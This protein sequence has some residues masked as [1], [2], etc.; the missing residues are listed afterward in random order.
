MSVLTRRSGRLSRCLVLLA[1][2][3]GCTDS[4]DETLGTTAQAVEGAPTISS[5]KEDY[6]P[7]ETA[8]LSGS[9]FAGDEDVVVAIQCTDGCDDVF[10]EAADPGGAFTTEYPIEEHHLGATCHVTATGQSS[11][12]VAETYFTDG[13]VRVLAAPSGISFTLKYTIYDGTA[14]EA[15]GSPKGGGTRTITAGVVN[16]T[17]QIAVAPNESIKLGAGSTSLQDTAFS[18]WKLG[19]TVVSSTSTFCV[20]GPVGLLEYTANFVSPPSTNQNPIVTCQNVSATTAPNTCTTTGSV[21]ASTSD[22]DGDTV[23]CTQTPAGP[24]ALGTTPVNVSCDDGKGGSASCTGTVTLTDDDRPTLACGAAQQVECTSP[25]GASATFSA[26]ATDNCGPV[27]ASCPG[28]GSTF[29]VGTS[30][31]S[32]SATDASGND[33]SCSTTITV[34]DT[35]SPDIACPAPTA[36]ECTGN[37]QAVVDVAAAHASD[38]CGAVQTDDPGPTAYPLGTTTFSLTATDAFGN[39]SSCTTNV[40]V[41]DTTAPSITCPAPVKAECESNHQAQVDPG[42]AQGADVCG[43]ANVSGATAGSFPLGTTTTSYTARDEIGLA[44]SCTSSVTVEDTTAPSIACPTPVTTECTGNSSATVDVAAATASDL[45]GSATASDPAPASYPL[46]TTTV[47]QTATDEAGLQASC[48][49]SVTVADTTAPSISC[50]A[51]ASAECTGNHSAFVDPGTAIAADVC[52]DVSVQG[53]GAGVYPLGTTSAAYVATDALGLQSSCASAVTV[54][55]TTA[56]S[57]SC[58]APVTA[59]CTG[60]HSASVDVAPASASDVCGDVTT[61]DPAEQ[62][63]PLGTTT[64][65]ETATDDSGQTATCTTEVTIVDTTAPSISCPAPVVAE[66]TGNRSAT[67]DVAAGVASDVCGDASVTDPAAQ[68]YPLGTTPV[69]ETATDESGLTASCSTSVTVVDTTAPTF[70]ALAPQSV[71]GNCSGAALAFTKPTATDGCDLA[72]VTCSA[73]AGNSFGANTITCTAQDPSGNTATTTIAVNVIQP[74]QVRFGSPLA[75]DNVAD[76]VE[77]DADVPNIFQVKSTIPHQ[78]TLHS[79]SGADVTTSVAVS[80]TIAV[81]LRD[82]AGAA[83]DANLLLT[84][85]GVGDAGGVMALVDGKYKYNL[86]TTGYKS[87]TASSSLFFDSVVRVSYSNAPSIVAG[88]EDVRLE[89][90]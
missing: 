63:Y 44:A 61:S 14:C 16:S 70:A 73:L 84:S 58:P 57:I 36:A 19:G 43:E 1:S 72:T 10:H 45:C 75:D 77:T 32:C 87:G 13:N 86:K 56:P 46:G 7:G 22:P 21:I 67:V 52:G 20:R 79:C 59:E 49:T 12:L 29:P 47:A 28:S 83:S 55:D 26:S 68:S 48:T 27:S 8:L 5:D 33:A 62:S 78:V 25:S 71:L 50:P 81:T 42:A 89:S 76:N 15:T 88:S 74:L 23:S 41:N 3:V 64:V 80:V 90:K 4:E 17:N 54:V 35:T 69:F 38:L 34:V 37:H 39:T 40:S 6:S 85:T 66:C 11:M 60:N 9:G 30:S 18:Q 53:P 31:T 82:G 51:P 2:A 24:Y 65:S